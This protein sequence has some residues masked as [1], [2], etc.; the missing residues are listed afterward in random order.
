METAAT[1]V[2]FISFSGLI[3]V[4]TLFSV[5]AMHNPEDVTEVQYL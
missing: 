5:G 2:K 3:E 4:V 1:E